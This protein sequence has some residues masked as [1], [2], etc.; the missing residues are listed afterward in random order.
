MPAGDV[1]PDRGAEVGLL[2]LSP[3]PPPSLQGAVGGTSFVG[4]E[5]AP[6][7]SGVT[8]LLSEPPSARRNWA[9]CSKGTT[10]TKLPP[11]YVIDRPC[12]FEMLA[13]F[14]SSIHFWFELLQM[15]T[16][17]PTRKRFTALGC[18][19]AELRRKYPGTQDQGI[20]LESVPRSSSKVT[21]TPPS[22]PT[23][24][25]TTRA[26]S[27]RC[28]ELLQTSTASSTLKP[29]LA[30]SGISGAA[31]SGF[32]SVMV[33]RGPP[34]ALT[35]RPP[36]A[37][38]WHSRAKSSHSAVSLAR[39]R[40]EGLRACLGT[41]SVRQLPMAP[42]NSSIAPTLPWIKYSSTRGLHTCPASWKTVSLADGVWPTVR[43]CSSSA[44]MGL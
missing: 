3:G 6:S 35:T 16:R 26:T 4:R 18:A 36:P 14:P 11:L 32:G 29:L 40:S 37:P 20:I 8:W 42:A 41:E 9:A 33:R 30:G 13:T 44:T 7:G 1:N 25:R 21:C 5:F 38:C 28:L 31:G 12:S 34:G 17:S 43:K 22:S 24:V 10:L 15:A 19:A 2:A 27:Q 23:A 39:T